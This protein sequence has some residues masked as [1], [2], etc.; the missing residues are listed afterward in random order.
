MLLRLKT[1][2]TDLIILVFKCVSNSQKTD[3]EVQ[4]DVKRLNFSS[5]S[6]SKKAYFEYNCIAKQRSVILHQ[7]GQT[8][9]T[10]Q[11]LKV[12]LATKIYFNCPNNFLG[13]HCIQN[14]FYNDAINRQLWQSQSCNL[15]ILISC[16][17]RSKK[18]VR[19]VTDCFLALDLLVQRG[20][21]NFAKKIILKISDMSKIIV[22]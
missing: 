17:T 7:D 15:V 10:M 11:L 4:L 21:Y 9:K 3:T 6:K 5:M 20:H 8:F 16:M 12:C 13:P 22:T 19:S 2:N 18:G 1:F 14:D